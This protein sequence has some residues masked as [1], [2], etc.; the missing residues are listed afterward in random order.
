MQSSS[1]HRIQDAPTSPGILYEP[2]MTWSDTEL[3]KADD[4]LLLLRF[5]SR[6]TIP[7]AD[8]LTDDR[9]ARGRRMSSTSSS[10][11]SID[12]HL[13]PVHARTRS[14]GA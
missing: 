14:K 1:A 3:A 8:V 4:L 9:L 12:H 13:S 11:P 10:A 7:A 2:R 5:R 6:E